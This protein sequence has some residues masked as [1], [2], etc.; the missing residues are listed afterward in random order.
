M[1]APDSLD[2]SVL[3]IDVLTETAREIR[4]RLSR[5]KGRE[6]V[7]EVD[8]RDEDEEIEMDRIGEHKLANALEKSR[9]PIHVFSEHGNFGVPLEQAVLIAAC[10]PL[11]GSSIVKHGLE[12]V[13]NMVYSCLGFFDRAGVPVFS[14]VVDVGR[15]V[16]YLTKPDGSYKRDLGTGAETKLA[17]RQFA[18]LGDVRS[19]AAYTM[20]PKMLL[21]FTRRFGLLLERLDPKTQ[22]LPNGGPALI[23][24]LLDGKTDVYLV[25][26]EPRGEVDPALAFAYRSGLQVAELSFAAGTH[27]PYQFIP[28]GKDLRVDAIVSPNAE[29]QAEI[30]GVLGLSPAKAAA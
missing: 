28:G 25:S 5:N 17:P 18:G 20:K 6:V 1:R 27:K 16:L 10:D 12:D 21:E 7:G 14:G 30:M 24:M 3:G 23:P 15:N 11:D 13:L 22:I 8:G 19:V 4:S 2:I 29:V 9:G 26:N